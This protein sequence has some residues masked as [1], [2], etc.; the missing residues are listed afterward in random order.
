MRLADLSHPKTV[1]KTSGL[2]PEATALANRL[3]LHIHELDAK[4]I[5]T[6]N[7]ILDEVTGQDRPPQSVS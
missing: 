4:T 1:V 7:Q 5:Q 2:S 6:L 3:A